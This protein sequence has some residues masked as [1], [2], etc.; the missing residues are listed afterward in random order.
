[1][2]DHSYL[3]IKVSTRTHIV[4]IKLPFC[5]VFHLQ[6]TTGQNAE[7]KQINDWRTMVYS[8]SVSD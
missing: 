6:R 5:A 3:K 1:M 4:Q 7:K 8:L 2:Y